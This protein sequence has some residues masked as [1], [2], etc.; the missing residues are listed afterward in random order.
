[1]VW[2]S[3]RWQGEEWCEIGTHVDNKGR[4]DSLIHKA[5]AIISGAGEEALGPRA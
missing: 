1:M 3:E 5:L 2:A 4:G